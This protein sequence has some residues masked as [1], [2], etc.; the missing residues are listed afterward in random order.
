MRTGPPS[1]PRRVLRLLASLAA[2]FA[3]PAG[4]Q[5][6][7]LEAMVIEAPVGG[8]PGR[9]YVPAGPGPHPAVIMLPD[10]HGPDLR[11]GF[12]ADRLV[13]D[14]IAVLVVHAWAPRGVVPEE[15]PA[16]ETDPAV[17]LPDLRAATAALRA[18]ARIDPGRIGVFGFGLG[19]ATATLAHA[20]GEP[21]QGPTVAFYPPCGELRT[22]LWQVAAPRK[23]APLLII[24]AEDDAAGT[25]ETCAALL[26]DLEGPDGDARLVTV[27]GATYGFDTMPP[28]APMVEQEWPRPGGGWFRV[29]S[30]IMAAEEA[31]TRAAW[32]LA[33]ALR[34]PAALR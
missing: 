30:D 34:A 16:D 15:A 7:T 17:L 1:L 32:F 14:G 26:R 23:A 29:R 28:L 13:D 20:V 12:H 24:A 11:E 8:I 10:Q 4:A 5:E 19:G 9:L 18:D 3:A 31:R 6:M 25:P 2:M 22:M 33:T 27:P 21:L